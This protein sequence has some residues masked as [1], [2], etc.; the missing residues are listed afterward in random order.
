MISSSP[1]PKRRILFHG[2]GIT[3]FR[4][5]MPMPNVTGVQASAT[6]TLA[7]L[8]QS[9]QLTGNRGNLIHAEAP[10]RLFVKNAAGSANANIH[11][12]RQSLGKRFREDVARNFDLIV[13]SL[14]NFIRPGVKLPNLERALKQLDGTVPFIVLGAGLQGR[15]QLTELTPSV[16]NV[17]AILDE[18]AL[19]FGVRGQQTG[20]WLADNGFK[21]T[22]V[23]G[24]PSLYCF[25]QSILTID[26]SQVR[27]KGNQAGVLT[28]GYLTVQGGHNFKRGKNLAESFKNTQPSYVFQDEFFTYGDVIETSFSFNEGTSTADAGILNELMTRETGVPVN[29]K[30]YYYFSDSGAWRQAA[31]HYDVYIGDRFHGGVAALQ[32]GRPAVFLTHDNRVA[33]LTEH[34]SLPNIPTSRFKKIGLRRTLNELLSDDA[35]ALMKRTY[36]QRFEQFRG[37]LARHGIEL[38]TRING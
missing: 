25:P 11:V 34:F 18:Q 7:A 37:S 5:N 29:F 16:R 10:A 32:A 12:L 17:L 27:A 14:A 38:S 6:D 1:P 15:C 36:R 23:L 19:I 8:R 21:N 20:S 28:A 31:M 4:P 33:E 2:P 13:L 3:W 9:H 26:A 24:C 30:R 22:E 35:I